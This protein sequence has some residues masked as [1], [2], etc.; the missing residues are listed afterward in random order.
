MKKSTFSGF[1]LFPNREPRRKRQA[2]SRISDF[3]V[4]PAGE[5]IHGKKGEDP[6]PVRSMTPAEPS[7]EDSLFSG[8]FEFLLQIHDGQQAVRVNDDALPALFLKNAILNL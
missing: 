2:F 7:G 5:A 1:P 8:V 3:S 4:S 6:G